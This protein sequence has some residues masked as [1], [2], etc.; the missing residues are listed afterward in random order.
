MTAVLGVGAGE[1]RAPSARPEPRRWDGVDQWIVSA[2]VVLLV[3]TQRIGVPFGDTSIGIALPLS[4]V[5][6]LLLLA[7]R[8]LRVS[9]LRGELLLLSTTL[10]LASTALVGITGG[11]PSLSSLM[12]LLAIYLPWVLRT[13]S[14]DARA[15]AH[16]AGLVFIRV[17]LVVAALGVF[18]FVGQ[19]LGVWTYEDL[20]GT[21]LPPDLLVPNYNFTIPLAYGSELFKSNGFLMLEPSAF[22]QFC[23]LAALIAL[24]LRRPAWQ[25]LVL[26]GGIASAVSGTGIILLAVGVALMV[27]RARH[28]L[29]PAYVVAFGTVL[30]LVALSPAASVLLNR[31]EEVSQPESSGYARFVAP[32]TQVLQGLAE[33]PTRYVTGGG[34]GT[35]ERLLTSRRD[36]V[37]ADVLYSIV[38]KLAFEY[39]L[40]AGGVFAIFLIVSMLDGAPWRVVPGAL[41]VMTFFLSGALLQPQT[42]FVAWIFTGLASVEGRP[43]RRS[44]RPPG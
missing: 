10:V 44:P 18:Q 33:D 38:P 16:R 35:A 5:A 1:T 6:V 9:R 11:S 39:G 19:L 27:V 8:S 24:M 3:L 32:Y 23:A 4:Y 13:A 41:V 7:R 28:R 17:M 2:L 36:G 40:I 29:R 43:G 12:L 22:S 25:V 21:W 26:V 34:P 14:P 15:V 42:A 30:A 31:S 20:L 37:G